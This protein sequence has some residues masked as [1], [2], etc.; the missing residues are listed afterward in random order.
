MPTSAPIDPSL[1]ADPDSPELI[2]DE[3]P[4]VLLRALTTPPAMPWDQARAAELSARLQT[5]LPADVVTWK[6]RR[7]TPWRPGAVARFLAAYV[8]RADVGGGLSVTQAFEG[9]PYAFEFLPPGQRE[10]M[11]RQF[12]LAAAAAGVAVLVAALAVVGAVQARGEAQRQLS[13][14]ELTLERR[15]RQ[16]ASQA[17]LDRRDQA[18]AAGGLEAQRPA[19]MLADLAWVAQSRADPVRLEAVLWEPGLTAIEVRG[20]EEPFQATDRKVQRA[21]RPV[22]PGVALWGISQLGVTP[23][24]PTP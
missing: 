16:A 7:L 1:F 13:S 3:R 5:P 24:G 18:L 2:A 22:R 11:V 17:E 8:R 20:D 23:D 6:L 21:S 12:T 10:A 19:R 15:A 4:Q 9:Q 14:L